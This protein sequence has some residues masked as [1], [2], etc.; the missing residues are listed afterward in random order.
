ML[1]L[2]LALLVGITVGRGTHAILPLF[3]FLSLL[4]LPLSSSLFLSFS[5]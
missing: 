4:S 3:L 5:L 1:I 2:L